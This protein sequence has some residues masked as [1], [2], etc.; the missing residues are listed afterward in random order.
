MLG[1]I[2]KFKISQQRQPRLVHSQEDVVK[3]WTCWSKSFTIPLFFSAPHKVEF[4][5]FGEVSCLGRG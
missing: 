5:K 4:A 2:A 1:E 3:W